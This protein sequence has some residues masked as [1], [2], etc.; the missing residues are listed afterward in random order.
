[1]KRFL[2]TCWNYEQYLVL[3]FLSLLLTSAVL[4]CHLTVNPQHFMFLQILHWGY[5]LLF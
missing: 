3:Q 5:E 4:A 2:M 1:M